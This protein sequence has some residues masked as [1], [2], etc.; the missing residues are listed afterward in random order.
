MSIHGKALFLLLSSSGMRLGE[1]LRLKPENIGLS[2][3]PIRVNIRGNTTKS[4]NRRWAFISDEAGEAIVNVVN[5]VEKGRNVL[6]EKVA[7]GS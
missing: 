4:G 7:V 2:S 1:V 3:D 6:I 5:K